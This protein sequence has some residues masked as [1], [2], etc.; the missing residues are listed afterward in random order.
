MPTQHV[1][2]NASKVNLMEAD[3]KLAEIV[4]AC[5]LINADGASIVGCQE[6]GRALSERVTGIDLFQRL[7]ELSAEKG[8]KVTSSARRRKL[9]RGWGGGAL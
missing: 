2:V 7:V 1:V 4:N 9:S 8:Y 6:A 5:P 3:P